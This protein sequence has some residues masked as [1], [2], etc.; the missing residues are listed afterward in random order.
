MSYKRQWHNITFSGRSKIDMMSRHAEET[1]QDNV[2]TVVQKKDVPQRLY[3][4]VELKGVYDNEFHKDLTSYL[5]GQYRE[6]DPYFPIYTNSD[7]QT[8]EKIY[9]TEIGY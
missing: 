7:G 6:L 1:D 4:I 9:T 2:F 5:T 3:N 8:I